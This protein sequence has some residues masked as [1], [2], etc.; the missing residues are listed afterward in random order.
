MNETQPGPHEIASN[1]DPQSNGI[2]HVFTNANLVGQKTTNTKQAEKLFSSG[3]EHFNSKN[4]DEAIKCLQAAIVIDQSVARY[5]SY[6]GLA[7][8]KKG[9]DGYAQAEFKVALFYDPTDKI[10]LENYADPAKG[11]VKT[12][13]T[14]I[15]SPETKK[16]FFSTIKQIFYKS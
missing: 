4:T 3:V 7:V 9:W 5:H 10:A 8:K 13:K 14:D 12:L 1:M 6:L 11:A 2:N 16:G 15:Q